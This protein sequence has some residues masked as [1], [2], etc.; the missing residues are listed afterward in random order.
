MH[1]GSEG[2]TREKRDKKRVGEG[3]GRRQRKSGRRKGGDRE[4]EREGV[5]TQA[6]SHKTARM[7]NLRSKVGL[8]QIMRTFGWE[9]K[10]FYKSSV[11]KCAIQIFEKSSVKSTFCINVIVQMEKRG[12]LGVM[13]SPKSFIHLAVIYSG[14]L[15]FLVY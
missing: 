11:L 14:L 5:R 2:N 3:K 4:R 15:K 13:L 1:T 12:E 7:V 10:S 6:S 8:A 9:N